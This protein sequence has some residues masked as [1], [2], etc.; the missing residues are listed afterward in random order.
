M[1]GFASTPADALARLRTEPFDLVITH[2]GH[3][4]GEVEDESAAVSLLRGIRRD[5]V[6]VP[7]VVFASGAHIES[8]K[9]A[10][11]RLGAQGYFY[12]WRA[13]T[14]AIRRVFDPGL[15]TG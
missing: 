7:V 3:G 11:L 4:M 8:N 1:V 14:E 6:R 9:P 12:S 15:E 10:A 2:W 5:D 13:L